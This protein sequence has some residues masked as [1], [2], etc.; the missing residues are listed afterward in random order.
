M[1][2]NRTF[3]IVWIRKDKPKA[4]NGDVKPDKIIMYKGEELK[5]SIGD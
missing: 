4:L 5:V 2:A 3:Q 1:L